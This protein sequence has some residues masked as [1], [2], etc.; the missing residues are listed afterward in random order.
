ME[1]VKKCFSRVG[2]LRVCF[3]ETFDFS[4]GTGRGLLNWVVVA[5]VLNVLISR[6]QFFKRSIDSINVK[7]CRCFV[8]IFF[9]YKHHIVGL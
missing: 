8:Y 1:G 7:G 2:S 4:S 6:R 3:L 9:S 5:I